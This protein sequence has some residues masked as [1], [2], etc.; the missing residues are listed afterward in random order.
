MRCEGDF[1]K[2]LWQRRI[3]AEQDPLAP[4]AATMV[5]VQTPDLCGLQGLVRS[6]VQTTGIS[7]KLQ[8][9]AHRSA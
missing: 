6:T 3:E 9:V 2:T 8:R 4:D 1:R 7:L 5:A